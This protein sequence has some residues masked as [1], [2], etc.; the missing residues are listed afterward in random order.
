MTVVLEVC[1]IRPECEWD[2]GHEVAAL[3][4]QLAQAH[5]VLDAHGGTV[6]AENRGNRDRPTGARFVVRLPR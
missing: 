6:R 5:E 3:V 2:E 1:V 4:L